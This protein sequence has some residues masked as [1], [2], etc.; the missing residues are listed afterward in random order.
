MLPAEVLDFM[1]SHMHEG[2][3]RYQDF[4]F[5]KARDFLAHIDE[6][7][8]MCPKPGDMFLSS[9]Y[10]LSQGYIT[11]YGAA[12]DHDFAENPDTD[13]LDSCDYPAWISVRD[14]CR[15][16]GVSDMVLVRTLRFAETAIEMGVEEIMCYYSFYGFAMGFSAGLVGMENGEVIYIADDKDEKQRLIDL[17]LQVCTTNVA[18]RFMSDILEETDA[19]DMES[20]PDGTSV[21]VIRIDEVLDEYLDGFDDEDEDDEVFEGEFDD[22]FGDVLDHMTEDLLQFVELFL[23]GNSGYM[24]R[25]DEFFASCV[26]AFTT[27]WLEGFDAQLYHRVNGNMLRSLARSRDRLYHPFTRKG[28]CDWT[29]GS[30]AERGL[31]SETDTRMARGSA[32]YILKGLV[33]AGVSSDELPP[34]DKDDFW[35]IAGTAFAKGRRFCIDEDCVPVF[36]M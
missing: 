6:D 24:R 2:N 26:N 10:A 3:E 11:G 23:L 33:E 17:A 27:W 16:R 25:E 19:F 5:V 21:K 36:E 13:V 20:L 8:V 31:L 34:R 9:L 29:I 12:I 22:D 35:A 14:L 7:E 30:M 32:R 1:D 4:V 15:E 18:H 28:M